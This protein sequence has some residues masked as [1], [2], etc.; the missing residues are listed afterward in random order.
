MASTPQS[1]SR[2]GCSISIS[3]LCRFTTILLH[4]AKR[5]PLQRQRETTDEILRKGALDI[6]HR[7]LRVNFRGEMLGFKIV[8]NEHGGIAD[9]ELADA[10]KLIHI[11]LAQLS[12][13]I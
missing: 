3:G 9:P 2:G 8:V 11:G 7:D 10:R 4:Q 6:F 13:G 5:F 1:K 12:F